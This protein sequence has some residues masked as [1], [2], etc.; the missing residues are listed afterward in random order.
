MKVA[1][2]VSGP[3]EKEGGTLRSPFASIRLRCLELIPTLAKG[4][5]TIRVVPS[6]G[7]PRAIREEGLLGSDV[8]VFPKMFH[9]VRP[10]MDLLRHAGVPVILDV[11]ENVYEMID[12]REFYPDMIAVADEV[13]ASS[14]ALADL[15]E[16]ES[17]RKARFI[18][19]CVE[20]DRQAPNPL[21]SDGPVELLWFGSAAS[22]DRVA[23]AILQVAPVLRGRPHRLTIVTALTDQLRGVISEAADGLTVEMIEWSRA[24]QAAA[25][26]RAQLVLLPT[27]DDPVSRVKS[28]NR[29]Q[30]ALWSGC[31]PLAQPLDAYR[32]FEGAC[33]VDG[34]LG[35][36]LARILEHPDEMQAMVAHGQDL[37][38]TACTPE[39]ATKAWL[40]L[41]EEAAVRRGRAPVVAPPLRFNLGSRHRS[42]AGYVNV[43]TL[44][45]RL[46]LEPDLVADPADLSAVADGSVEEIVAL[47]LVE[48]YRRLEVPAVL[49]EWVRVLKPGGRLIVECSNFFEVCRRFLEDPYERAEADERGRLT[50][51]ALYGD[52]ASETAEEMRHWAYT[53]VTLGRLMEEAGL[54]L[55]ERRLAQ[56]PPGEPWDMRLVGIKPE[57]S[58]QVSKG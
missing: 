49:R 54:V 50:M 3:L 10:A 5:H 36:A 55:A 40:S 45:D 51:W 34:D 58:R 13:V 20:Y 33:V 37:V 41:A 52:P 11:A 1:Y 4:G 9:D 7:L 26:A 56:F 8:A 14:P 28:A 25:L 44:P 31:L 29:L 43:D 24:S 57:L 17:G 39:A 38:R 15:I 16:R 19:D 35:A 47:H 48:R 42:L 12:F 46:G 18:P 30:E 27:S 22:A 21:F 2:V 53:R 32:A 23:D 6:E